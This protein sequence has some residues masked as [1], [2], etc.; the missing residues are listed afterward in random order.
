[1]EPGVSGQNSE[2]E[3]LRSTPQLRMTPRFKM[4]VAGQVQTLS[5][6]QLSR[7]SCRARVRAPL[8]P[9]CLCPIKEF[10]PQPVR[11]SLRSRAEAPV[12]PFS[13]G[14]IKLSFASE[15]NHL[16][17]LAPPILGQE[18]P[19]WGQVAVWCSGPKC[20]AISGYIK[21]STLTGAK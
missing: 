19:R 2:Q 3:R 14:K 12:F 9:L 5:L 17:L 15:L 20:N 21:R 18:D 1:M 10:R 13:E 4:A 6:T 7:R 16:I 8:R 11:E